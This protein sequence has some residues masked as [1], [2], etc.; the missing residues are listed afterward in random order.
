MDGLCFLFSDKVIFPLFELGFIVFSIY[1]LIRD[2]RPRSG[3]LA[4]LKRGPESWNKLYL[5]Y[6]I[7]SVVVMQVINSAEACVGH[8]TLISVVDLVLLFYL[9]F[10]NSWFRNK[11]IEYITRSQEKK[12]QF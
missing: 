7:A 4:I 10:Y 5:A 8:K 1:A 2:C 11:M 12:E 3:I 6:G 9:F